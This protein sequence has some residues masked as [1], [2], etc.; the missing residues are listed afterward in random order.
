[1]DSEKKIHELEE[2]IE[3]TNERISVST[4]AGIVLVA[5]MV[6]GS[7]LLLVVLAT[8]AGAVAGLGVHHTRKWLKNRRSK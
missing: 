7:P 4:G 3:K 2:K 6:A 5:A 1:M 8:A